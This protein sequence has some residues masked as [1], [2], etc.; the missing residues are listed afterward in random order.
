MKIL[1]A[2]G[3]L[4]ASAAAFAAPKLPAAP[5]HPPALKLIVERDSEALKPLTL[6][7][8]PNG[9]FAGTIHEEEAALSVSGSLQADRGLTRPILTVALE[10]RDEAGL[11]K[12]DSH[13]A[14]E[15]GR[16]LLGSLWLQAHPYGRDSGVEP[17][18]SSLTFYLEP[19]AA[20]PPPSPQP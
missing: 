9:R 8:T 11:Q 2:V 4:L 1:F 5:P 6:C 18:R 12:L 20:C 17:Q 19:L 7:L 3:L 16:M 14:L 13:L 10:W 15:D